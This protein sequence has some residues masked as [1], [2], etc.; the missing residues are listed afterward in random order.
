MSDSCLVA[1]QRSLLKVFHKEYIY[2]IYK[3]F[4][5]REVYVIGSHVYSFEF[6]PASAQISKFCA[7]DSVLKC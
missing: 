4:Y 7:L 2:Y 6:P 1:F 3:H 5:G